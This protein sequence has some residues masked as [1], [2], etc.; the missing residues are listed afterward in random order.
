MFKRKSTTSPKT[1]N[2]RPEDWRRVDSKSD[3]KGISK[4]EIIREA[5]K[6]YV[7]VDESL[8]EGKKLAFIDKDGGLTKLEVLWNKD[9][10]LDVPRE[11][12]MQMVVE[13]AI[14]A[15]SHEG[16]RLV[17]SSKGYENLYKVG[18]EILEYSNG[19]SIF[20]N[21]EDYDSVVRVI[22]QFKGSK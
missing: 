1:Y 13:G 21:N 2:L 20:G 7:I 6:L 10:Q 22:K 15:C 8:K 18:K 3:S 14:A 12:A 17:I 5:I 19:Y 9:M 16:D 4:S 11:E